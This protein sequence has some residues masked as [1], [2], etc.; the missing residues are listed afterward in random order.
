MWLQIVLLT[1]K[2]VDRT[3]DVI[4]GAGRRQIE[5]TVKSLQERNAVARENGD[6]EE[7]NATR[8]AL[9]EIER[10]LQ[11]RNSDTPVKSV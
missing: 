9:D 2:L 8:A 10:Q 5:S 6:L 3:W 1:L 7:I 4:D 11:S